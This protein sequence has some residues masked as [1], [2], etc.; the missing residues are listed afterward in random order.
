M[1]TNSNKINMSERNNLIDVDK[2]NLL[3]ELVAKINSNLQLENILKEIMNAT[4]IIMSAEASSLFLLSE[5]KKSLILTVPT[6]PLTAELSGIHI[7]VTSG[8]SGWVTQNK[9][10]A[11]VKDVSKDPRFGGDL[12]KNSSFITKNIICVPLINHNDEVIGALQA[13]NSRQLEDLGQDNAAIFQTMASQAA[14]AIENALLHKE[15]LNNQLLN[16]EIE[17]ASTIQSGFWPEDEPM[18]PNYKVAG[19]SIPAKNVGGDYFDYIPLPNKNKWG[20]TVADVTGK[21]VS[22]ALLM[23][24]M[25]ASLR[26]HLEYSN[27]P[28]KSLTKVNELI[29]KDSPLDKFI[30]AIYCELDSIKN[31]IRYVNAGHNNPYVLDADKNSIF[32]LEVGGLM[33]GILDSVKYDE[34]IYVLKSNQKI[35]LFSDGITEARNLEG[36]FFGEKRFENWLLENKH[37]E[38][39]SMVKGI[40]DKLIHFRNGAEQSDDIT[41][42]VIQREG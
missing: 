8:I 5:D 25:R 11:V 15:R 4:T 22:A 42:V 2:L 21:G 18:I 24:T 14:I 34:E 35:I 31:T 23:A 12:D 7:P 32:T 40:T 39:N 30:T 28:S 19:C 38:P 33:L 37:L 17:L 36:D 16:K 6:G 29:F 3:M 13:I 20:F 1:A 41:I 26:S 27:T 9:K 10:L